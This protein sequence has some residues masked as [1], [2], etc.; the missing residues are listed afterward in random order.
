M[1]W[2]RLS[3]DKPLILLQRGVKIGLI[4]VDRGI[5]RA[6]MAF[7]WLR[8]RQEFVLKDIQGSKMYLKISDKGLS[9]DLY[10][11]G[12]REDK[13]TDEFRKRLK[14]GMVV[15]D[16]GAN[17]GYYALME[18]K[19]AGQNGKV[20]AIEPVADNVALLKR[21]IGANGYG[22]IEVFEMAIGDKNC[23]KSIF[24]SKQSNLST[25]CKNID[26][27]QSGETADVEVMTLD[28]FLEGKRLPDIVRMDVEGY[29]HEILQGMSRT[30]KKGRG[31]QLFIEVHADFMGVEKTIALFRMMKESGFSHCHAIIDSTDVLKFAEKIVSK[32]ILPEQGEFDRSIDEMIAEERFHHGLYHLFV[33]KRA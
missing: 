28:S 12:K 29:E 16:I 27:D 6:R 5:T 7:A 14:P 24:L 22:N 25:F 3:Q 21:N 1:N 18:A 15:A 9:S 17:I 4:R 11:R 2:A 19:A 10:L 8:H 31:M 23:R 32:E 26:L 30:M 20:Y 33:E 13:A